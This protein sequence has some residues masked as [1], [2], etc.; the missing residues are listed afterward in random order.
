MPSAEVMAEMSH[1]TAVITCL[2]D[3]YGSR[4]AINA[5]EA[6]LRQG[7]R[8]V[9]HCERLRRYFEPYASVDYLDHY[10]KFAAP[11]FLGKM[12]LLFLQPSLFRPRRRV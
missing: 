11:R 6:M 12:F 2:V 8:V 3:F 10:V 1:R 5:D 4:D 7:A 9:V